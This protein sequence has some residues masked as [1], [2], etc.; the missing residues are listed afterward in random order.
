MT[1]PILGITI[2]GLL[3]LGLFL[4]GTHKSEVVADLAVEQAGDADSGGVSKQVTVRKTTV[5]KLP[6][7]PAG[8]W[9]RQAR[10]LREL[11][12][13][14]PREA[15][16]ALESLLG[17]EWA[18]D[19]Q[20]SLILEWGESDPAGV[21]AFLMEHHSARERIAAKVYM[22]L[23]Q[24]DGAAA[25]ALLE[26]DAWTVYRKAS[27]EEL[28]RTEASED[29]LGA[30]LILARL[31]E[32]ESEP[33]LW[34]SVW[35][36]ALSGGSDTVDLLWENIDLLGA[37]GGAV[38]KGF[39]RAWG[40]SDPEAAIRWSHTDGSDSSRAL[41]PEL[42]ERWAEVDPLAATSY[43]DEE[44]WTPLRGKAAI[45]AAK[46][47]SELDENSAILWLNEYQA[48]GHLIHRLSNK[49]L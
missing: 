48:D 19:L 30:A 7:S 29:P 43:L 21:I 22:Q 11:A 42:I 5:S 27:F 2:V 9:L 23:Y 41:L 39:I 35:N 36:R 6:L 10:E 16:L 3:V 24:E 4:L 8:N 34:R 13:T 14:S 44:T 28:I 25:L 33:A 26:S 1:K 32:G 40:E 37:E 45:Q 46:T 31:A 47:W 18:P 17:E 12:E 38:E 49:S 15:C 20:D